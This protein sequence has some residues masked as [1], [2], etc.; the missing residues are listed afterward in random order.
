MNIAVVSSLNCHAPLGRWAAYNCCTRS[1]GAMVLSRHLIGL[2]E[3][4][5]IGGIC[6]GSGAMPPAR[7]R[8]SGRR[9]TGSKILGGNFQSL[10]EFP[11]KK[12]A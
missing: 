12:V 8:G 5:D 9:Q 6:W 3:E 11:L 10:G 1:A 2:G 4:A 7:S